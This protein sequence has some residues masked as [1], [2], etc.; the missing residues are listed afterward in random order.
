MLYFNS[1]NG[2]IKVVIRLEEHENVLRNRG[3]YYTISCKLRRTAY[4][5]KR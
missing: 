4:A 3:S 2:F 5:A 1:T